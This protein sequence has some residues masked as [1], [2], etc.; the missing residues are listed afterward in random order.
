MIGHLERLFA[1]LLIVAP[2]YLAARM[3]WRRKDSREWALGAFWVIVISVGFLLFSGGHM[4]VWDNSGANIGA[5]VFEAAAARIKSG[6]GINFVPLKTIRGYFAVSGDQFYV[7][8]G[9]NII[10][11]VPLGFG[12]PLLWRRMHNFILLNLVMLAVPALVEFIQLFIGRSVDVD[13]VILNF[14]G[15][16]IGALA[17]TAVKL[18]FP[19][20]KTLA[21]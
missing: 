5:N 15:G 10:L 12:L 18:I 1:V 20:I 2:V 7:N 16:A 4:P 11:F 13:D 21:R 14:V 9:G 8:V 19:K 6:I 3:P 17:Y